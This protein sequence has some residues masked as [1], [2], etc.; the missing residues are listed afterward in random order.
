MKFGK[1][2]GRETSSIPVLFFKKP[3][4]EVMTSGLELSFK[5]R[6]H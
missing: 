5:T 2:L 6:I 3:L 1:V 4:H